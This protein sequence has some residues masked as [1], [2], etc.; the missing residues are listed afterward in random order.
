MYYETEFWRFWIYELIS[1]WGKFD[2]ITWWTFETKIFLHF[3]WVSIFAI[4]TIFTRHSI[5][6]IITINAWWT[7]RSRRPNLAKASV[8][9]MQNFCGRI[10]TLTLCMI[11]CINWI[12]TF[13]TIWN[14]INFK[15]SLWRKK[16]SYKIHVW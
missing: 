12:C 2:L 16:F 5:N 3:V 10:Y 6:P 7:N 4:F 1:R 8:W 11:C 13:A 14:R 9:I 15:N